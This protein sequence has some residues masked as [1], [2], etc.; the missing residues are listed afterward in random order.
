MAKPIPSLTLALILGLSLSAA[1]APPPNDACSTAKPIPGLE[2]PFNQTLDTTQATAD[3]DPAVSCVSPAPGKS[4]WYTFRPETSDAYAFDTTGSLPAGYNPVLTL[5]TGGCGGLTP[6]PNACARGRLVASLTAGTTYS[7][8]VAGASVVV[9]P[10]I[11]I[12]VNGF[13]LCPGGPGP[14]GGSCGTT[15]DV[16]VGE[17]VSARAYNGLNDTLLTEGTFAWSLGTNAN[18]ATATGPSAAFSYTAPVASTN[19]VLTWTPPGQTPISRQVTMIV[20]AAAVAPPVTLGFPEGPFP[21]A[22]GETATI[23]SPGGTL[24]LLVQRDAPEWRY[25]SIV[26]S[27]ASIV[28]AAGVPYVSDFSVSSMQSTEAVVGLELWTAAG[29]RESSL[30]T[31]PAYGSRTIRDVVKTAFGL[32]QTFGALLVSSTGYVTAGAKTWAPVSGGGTNGQ[33]AL[34]GDVRNPSSAAIL[35]TGESGVL[36]GVRQDTG[37]RTNIGV[38]NLSEKVCNVEFEARNEEGQRV[39][40]QLVLTVPATRYVQVSLGDATGNNLP[41]GSVRLTNATSGCVVGGVA[42]VIDNVTQDPFAVSQRKRP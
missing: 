18:P 32:E 5:Y 14:G 25:T 7:L 31:L 2:L 33:F 6:V 13:D 23:P 21:L 16:R 34:A 17:Q 11:R 37:F 10:E 29:R 27:V 38:Y 36:T 15:F 30:I 3:G 41:S 4:V 19:V 9:D 42:Y 28:N 1:A 8:L 22:A 20:N 35:L 24:K 39:G 40:S 26:P 12:A